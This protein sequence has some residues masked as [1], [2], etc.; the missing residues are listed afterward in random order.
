LNTSPDNIEPEF[1]LASDSPI[2]AI[3]GMRRG[4]NTDVPDDVELTQAADHL[5]TSKAVA[6]IAS[7][8]R[9]RKISLEDL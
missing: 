5:I 8:E 3:H 2:T 1:E 9:A 4:I 6:R 7:V